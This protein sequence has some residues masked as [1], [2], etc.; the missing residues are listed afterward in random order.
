MNSYE[1]A[2]HLADTYG[3]SD[4]AFDFVFAKFSSSESGSDSVFLDQE[5]G[6]L[7][8]DG[9][10]EL[11]GY[12]YQMKAQNV[13]IEN[14]SKQRFHGIYFT[15]SRLADILVTDALE[16]VS[17]N[18]LPKF[19]EPAVGLGAFVFSYIRCIWNQKMERNLH[20]L[21]QVIDRIYISDID[22]VAI[23]L[24]QRMIPIYVALKYSE[25]V[26]F[27]KENAIVV[28]ALFDLEKEAQTQ[29]LELFN[30][31]SGFD[32]V[33]SNPPYRLLKPSTGDTE[34]VR[35]EIEAMVKMVS[36]DSIYA[37]VTGVNNIY[38]LFVA[39]ILNEW[40]KPNGIVGLLIPRS[41]LT[42]NQSS[43]MRM[44][45]LDKFEIGNIYTIPEGS[46]YF[47]GIG[48]AFSLFTLKK[49]IQ[50][51]SI[52]IFVPNS[53]GHI[54]RHSPITT[55]Q[56]EIFR[57][58]TPNMSIFPFTDDEIKLLRSLE[59]LPKV[60]DCPQIVNLRGELD[61]SLDKQFMLEES[62]DFSF[63]QG[64]NI[65]FYGLK[66]TSKYVREDFFPRPKGKWVEKDRIACQQISNMNQDRRLKWSRIRK[67]AVLGNSCNFIAIDDLSLFHESSPILLSYLLAV[68]NSDF[69]NKRFKL[70]SANNHIS[71]SEIS[72]M[73]LVIPEFQIQSRI[74]LLAE[75]LETDFSFEIFNDIEN[76]L[77]QIF[78]LES[79]A[80]PSHHD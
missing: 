74:A 70:L 45:M 42:D 61:I 37:D 64:I 59:K 75:K 20:E 62:T 56:L 38:K 11:L 69:Q 17:P 41:L 68:F 57:M 10:V 40:V 2:A 44:K 13:S 8:T 27:R 31:K 16:K 22:E 67:D 66:E 49:G 3:D 9:V 80:I 76:L 21:Q 14:Y 71:N 15:D 72:N 47:P 52:N 28:N 63:V 18:S 4:L 6:M 60:K 32:L 24:L 36:K 54:E 39:K 50:S 43:K 65:G 51:T 46:K 78:G 58:S 73:P 23:A 55:T 33:I 53:E 77:S 79:I 19:L 29:L 7:N 25:E 34:V 48:Q 5:M 12:L 35:N 30:C 26:V 1:L